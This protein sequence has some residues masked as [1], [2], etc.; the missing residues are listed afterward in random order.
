MGFGV[1]S[2]WWRDEHHEHHIFTNTIIP[3]VGCSDPQF[4]PPEFWAQQPE[5]FEV[6]KLPQWLLRQ[7]LKVQHLIFLPLAV[8]L[9][10]Y[11]IK[12]DSLVGETRRSGYYTSFRLYYYDY[13]TTI[14]FLYCDYT[15]TILLLYCILLLYYY[16]TLL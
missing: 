14:L 3:G 15:V 16:N 6:H 8:V 13:T 5:L 11:G 10:P 1:S 12:I 2:K 7:I 4:D 9:G